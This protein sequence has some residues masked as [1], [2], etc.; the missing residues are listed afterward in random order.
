M[1]YK[2]SVPREQALARP[3]GP[4][5]HKAKST[6]GQLDPDELSR[7]LYVVLAEQKAHADR[8]RRARAEAANA[9]DSLG[10]GKKKS[11]EPR[12][13]PASSTSKAVLERKPGETG[14]DLISELR[15]AKSV[16][17]N[18]ETKDAQV[19]PVSAHPGDIAHEYHHVP[20]EAAKQF[21]RT[22][23]VDTMQSSLVHKL[24]KRALKFHLDGT[25]TNRTHVGD[26]NLAPHEQDRAMRRE[27]SRREK[28]LDRNQFQNTRILEEAAEIDEERKREEEKRQHR[29]TFEGELSRLRPTSNE[30][31]RTERRNSTGD[32]LDKVEGNRRS[33][34]VD[35]LMDTVLEDTTPPG[36]TDRFQ[37]HEHRVDWTQS[38]ETKHRSRLLLTPFLRKADSIWT[39]RGRLG[40]KGS[41]DKDESP[42]EQA[43]KSPMSSF[44]AKLRR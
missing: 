42:Q 35:Q 8:R 7:R 1:H 37:A 41:Q 3:P 15:R 40:S 12:S 20:Q 38:D 31:A 5:K 43:L 23:T 36:E 17:P 21:T 34:L 16:K 26:T 27:L 25:K 19:A 9:G 22:T 28:V 24:S 18:V 39:L 32:L 29:H 2:M 10:G 30:Y 6:H 44:F 14:T 13:K 11:S 33:L 4:A